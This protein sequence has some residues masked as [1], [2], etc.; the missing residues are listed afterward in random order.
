LHSVI[1]TDATTEWNGKTVDLAKIVEI[2][3][4]AE[5]ETRRRSAAP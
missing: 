3:E 2:A 5:I 4:I 1:I